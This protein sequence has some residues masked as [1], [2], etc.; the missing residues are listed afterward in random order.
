MGLDDTVSAGARD[1]EDFEAKID[2]EGGVYGALQYGLRADDFYPNL[3]PRVRE[4][5]NDLVIAFDEIDELV[6]EYHLAVRHASE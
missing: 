4:A 2:W 5:W 6:D 3:P 1:L